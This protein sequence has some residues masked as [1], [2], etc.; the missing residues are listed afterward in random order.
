GTG[1]RESPKPVV[2]E[3]PGHLGLRVQEERKRENLRVPEDMPVVAGTRQAPR[4]DGCEV[5]VGIP[6]GYQVVE[7]EPERELSV[8][9]SLDHHVGGAPTLPPGVAVTVADGPE[10]SS[11]GLVEGVAP[12]SF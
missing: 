5:G 11:L 2:D 9:I 7:G 10:A 8:G 6:G 3:L 1:R 12:R 4:S